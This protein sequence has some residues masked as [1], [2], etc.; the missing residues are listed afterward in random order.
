MKKRVKDLGVIVGGLRCLPPVCFS[1]KV[2]IG[3]EVGSPPSVDAV[4][5]GDAF[6]WEPSGVKL[7]IAVNYNLVIYP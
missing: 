1:G 5:L 4:V 7:S 2:K 3:D 6:S